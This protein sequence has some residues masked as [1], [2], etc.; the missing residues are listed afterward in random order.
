MHE[1]LS[2]NIKGRWPSAWYCGALLMLQQAAAQKC[3]A[4]CSICVY[5]RSNGGYA[6]YLIHQ[7]D[8][9]PWNVKPALFRLRVLSARWL[10]L[11]PWVVLL[12]RLMSCGSGAASSGG[13]W[14]D[15]TCT[16]HMQL[17][18]ETPLPLPWSGSTSAWC[19]CNQPQQKEA[20]GF[21]AWWC[22]CARQL[23]AC[24][25]AG[26]QQTPMQ[27]CIVGVVL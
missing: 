21:G 4:S 27:P 11:A 12:I 8:H 18:N 7:L 22:P 5:K 9:M 15:S 10:P 3:A 20:E 2:V 24:I 26:L 17:H 19:A 16:Q 6:M 14:V 25:A 23:T 13:G 1:K